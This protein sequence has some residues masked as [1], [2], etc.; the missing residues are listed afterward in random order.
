MSIQQMA[1]FVLSM[2]LA[3]LAFR[4]PAAAAVPATALSIVGF[5]AFLAAIVTQG[6]RRPVV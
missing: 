6:V 5:V 3:I 1:L 2:L 4:G